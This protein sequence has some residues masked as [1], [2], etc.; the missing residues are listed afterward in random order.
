MFKL[1]WAV[2][3][4]F[5]VSTVFLITSELAAARLVLHS[6]HARYAVL[7]AILLPWGFSLRALILMAKIAKRSRSDEEFTALGLFIAATPAFSYLLLDLG[8]AVSLH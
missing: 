2:K 3:L 6:V 1:S 8:V 5:V 7:V 4:V